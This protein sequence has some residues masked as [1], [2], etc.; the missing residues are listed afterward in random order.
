MKTTLLI[1]ILLLAAALP[2]FNLIDGDRTIA[3][4]PD[5]LA[6]LPLSEMRTEREKKGEI[7]INVWRGVSLTALLAR[8][9]VDPKTELRILS[10]DNYQALLTPDQTAG[11]ILALYDNGA[12][13]P[14]DKIRLVNPAIRDMFW[15]QNPILIEAKKKPQP[16]ECYKLVLLDKS[17][18]G[19]AIR[20]ELP[21]FADVSGWYFRDLASQIVSEPRGLWFLWGRDGVC[22]T[23]DYET[24]LH[25]AVIVR[26]D[27]ALELKS[28]DMPEGMWLKNLAAIQKDE[29]VAILTPRFVDM[30]EVKSLLGWQNIPDHVTELPGRTTKTGLPPFSDPWWKNV[31]GIQW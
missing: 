21:P 26:V 30:T 20:P 27:G 5:S 23:L 24:Y 19:L 16:F 17:L 18:D 11:A 7:K 22:Q 15:I 1:C 28:P 4:T 31:K 3:I 6:T 29:T 12:A 14:A 10:Q 8:Y 25:N 2:G 9:S 13:L